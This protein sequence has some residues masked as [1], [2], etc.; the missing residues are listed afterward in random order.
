MKVEHNIERLEHLLEL[1]KISAGELCQ[2]ISEGLK[3]PIQKKD[4]FSETIKLSDLKKIDNIF[5]KGIN[6]YLDPAPPVKTPDASIFFRKEEFHTDLNLESKKRVNEFEDLKHSITALAILS[7]KDFS[8]KLEVF[9]IE[10]DPSKI[11]AKVRNYLYPQFKKDKRDFLK[12]LIKKLADY[13]ILVFE[14]VETWNKKDVVNIDGF[15]LKPNT[16]VLKRNQS[17]MSR[18]LFT[19]AHEL[20]H[21]LLN[22]EEVEELD[23][24][25]LAQ[26]GLSKIETWCN[27]FAFYFLGG[28]YADYLNEIQ[29]ADESNDYH[30]ASIQR[31]SKNT[32]LSTLAIYTRLLFLKKINYSSYKNTK[33]SIIEAITKKKEK[34]R[35]QMELLKAQGGKIRGSSPKPLKS[36]LYVETIQNAFYEGIINEYEVC[37]KL[38]IKPEKLEKYI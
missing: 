20:G 23:Y 26:K 35:L 36:P 3:N 15:F 33:D 28:P 10:E 12:S 16:I 11:A 18:E 8:R 5:N 32:H 7:E 1:Y 34:E 37:R 30:H 2:T 19:L 22:E 38:N 29:K 24:G 17:S 6:Y 14:F 31:I 4:I 21:Y 27:E 13:N 25:V 9:S